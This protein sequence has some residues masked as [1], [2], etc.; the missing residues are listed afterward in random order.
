MPID[1]NTPLHVASVSKTMTAMAVLKL[2]EGGKLKLED[3]V[4]KFFPKFPYLYELPM[5]Y[6]Q[7]L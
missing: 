4:T 3:D 7:H 1:E 6:Q 5:Q 2:V